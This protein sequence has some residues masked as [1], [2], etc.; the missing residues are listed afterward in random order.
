MGGGVEGGG[1]HVD[2]TSG[3]E[4]KPGNPE[5]WLSPKITSS[6]TEVWPLLRAEGVRSVVRAAQTPCDH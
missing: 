1:L 2:S 5:G 3:S 6:E 4:E